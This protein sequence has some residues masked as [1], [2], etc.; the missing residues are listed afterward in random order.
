MQLPFID[1][2]AAF[3]WKCPRCQRRNIVKRVLAEL[4]FEQKQKFM[5]DHGIEF[6]PGEFFVLPKR[7]NCRGCRSEFRIRPPEDE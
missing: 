7:T 6:E 3:V 4:N 5:L 2:E 1:V